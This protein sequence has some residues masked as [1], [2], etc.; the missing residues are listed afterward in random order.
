[1]NSIFLKNEAA[2]VCN[3]EQNAHG[4]GLISKPTIDHQAVQNMESPTSAL[5]Q[6]VEYMHNSV[7]RCEVRQPIKC[8]I[9]P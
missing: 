7:S 8:A 4:L 1:M 6:L 2:P 5:S 9:Q 3:S